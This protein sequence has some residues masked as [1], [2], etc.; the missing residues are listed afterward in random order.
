MPVKENKEE[1]Q[2]TPKASAARA[3]L[4]VPVLKL[5]NSTAAP[6]QTK[7]AEPGSAKPPA[8]NFLNRTISTLLHHS[9]KISIPTPRRAV[10]EPGFSP[11]D[12]AAV[13]SNPKSN[14]PGEN[15]PPRLI[16]VPP[17]LLEIQNG[18]KGR[19]AWTSYQGKVYNNQPYVPFHPGGKGGLLRGAGKDSAKLFLEAHPWVNWDAILGEC[20]VVF[21]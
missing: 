4:E 1:E 10:L 3:H 17:S 6:E 11:L 8:S 14:L 7:V 16:R 19:D 15:M 2:T 13:A 5:D 18:R 21:W 12:W 20:L 9:D